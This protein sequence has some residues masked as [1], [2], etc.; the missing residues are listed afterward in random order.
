MGGCGCGCA[1]VGVC[2]CGRVRTCMRAG[3][4]V[5]VLLSSVELVMAAI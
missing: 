2:V 5:G 4:W 1:Y 3:G